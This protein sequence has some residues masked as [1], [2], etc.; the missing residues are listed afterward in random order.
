MSRTIFRYLNLTLATQWVTFCYG[1]PSETYRSN[2]EQTQGRL[3]PWIIIL[4]L[5][6]SLERCTIA[7]CHG[8]PSDICHAFAKYKVVVFQKILIRK[9]HTSDQHTL[10]KCKGTDF[11]GQPS[12]I[13]NAFQKYK[14]VFLHRI[15]IGKSDTS[16][17]HTL[18]RQIISFNNFVIPVSYNEEA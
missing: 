9:S 10:E 15:S 4:Y 14:V 18:E 16:D 7:H 13:Y 6:H 17:H 3:L 1:Q 12:D 11:H 8:Q 5:Y 2:N